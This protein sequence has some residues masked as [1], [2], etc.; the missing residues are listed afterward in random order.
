MTLNKPEKRNPLTIDTFHELHDCAD[1]CDYDT[2]IRAI[3]IRGAGG[4]FSAGG[5]IA[6]MKARI[7]AG[8]RGT[9]QVCRAGAE[10]NLRILNVKKPVIAQLEGAVTG[11]GLSL[12]LS[13]DF[14][15]ASET[16]KCAFSFVNMGFIPDT[17]ATQL[18][19]KSIGTTRAKEL[20]MSGRFFSGKEAADWGLFTEAI[21]A[22][23]VEQRVLEYIKKYSN[24]PTISYANIK[25]LIN[26]AQFAAFSD[27]FQAEIEAQ[28]ECELTKDYIEAVNA[29]LEKRKPVFV[30]K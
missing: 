11:A 13:C 5:D 28:G 18:V 2:D 23:Q 22:E 21:P 24:G 14:Q 10:C 4:C 29:F 7:D 15:I 17:G 19:T 12:A 20:F 26:R 3:V 25:A 6:A 9:R 16:A 27:G 30:G 1:L 8:I